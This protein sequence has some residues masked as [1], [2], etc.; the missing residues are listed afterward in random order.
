MRYLFDSSLGGLLTA[1]FVGY[2]EIEESEFVS[3]DDQ[4][5]FLQDEVRVKTQPE[6]AKRVKD[7]V[8]KTFGWDLYHYITLAFRA[9]DLEKDTVIARVIK[10]A[11]VHGKLYLQ[12]A[13]EEVVYF[14]RLARNVQRE[15]HAY[16]GLLRFQEIRG[17]YL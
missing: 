12:S 2:R 8:I 16:K 6:K 10:G 13:E 11:Y 3:E 14:T 17:G 1:V 7:G 5:S 9:D 15:V 4:A